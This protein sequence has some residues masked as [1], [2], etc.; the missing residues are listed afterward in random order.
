MNRKARPLVAAFLLLALFGCAS[1]PSEKNSW[2]VGE[3]RFRQTFTG[4]VERPN[5]LTGKLQIEWGKHR[6]TGRI[7]FDALKEWERL[8]EVWISG[9]S[10]HFSRV[11]SQEE[12]EG[13]RTETGVKGNW[14]TSSAKFLA[15][16]WEAERN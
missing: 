2:A 7:Y 6:Y 16:S 15:G 5:V 14:N 9:T 3:W 10:V 4:P 8:D 1:T 13:H 12:F 11:T